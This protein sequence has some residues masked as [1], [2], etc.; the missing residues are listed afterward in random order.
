MVVRAKT[1][2]CSL[3][4]HKIRRAQSMLGP[5]GLVIPAADLT[6]LRPQVSLNELLFVPTM[7]RWTKLLVFQA[8]PRADGGRPNSSGTSAMSR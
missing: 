5:T 1:G 6:S 2:L 4:R 8:S 7:V 3:A